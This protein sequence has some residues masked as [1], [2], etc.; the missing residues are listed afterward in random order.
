MVKI[1]IGAVR[2]LKGDIAPIADEIG[3]LLSGRLSR[4]AR[5]RQKYCEQ[6]QPL[7]SRAMLY[8]GWLRRQSGFCSSHRDKRPEKLL[9]TLWPGYAGRDR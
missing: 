3:A 2:L 6:L 5:A 8:S 4:V 9:P 1:S 7:A